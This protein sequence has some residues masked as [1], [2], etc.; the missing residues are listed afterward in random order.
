M[1]RDQL[2][3]LLEDIIVYRSGSCQETALSASPS[4][5]HSD[6]CSVDYKAVQQVSVQLPLFNLGAIKLPDLLVE[7]DFK[8]V[9]LAG[10]DALFLARFKAA[11]NRQVEWFK[12]PR[13]GK[14]SP[15]QLLLQ[16]LRTANV[17]R[18]LVGPGFVPKI[19]HSKAA[20]QGGGGRKIGRKVCMV[21]NL[22][23]LQLHA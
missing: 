1:N 9:H 14:P 10:L 7:Q 13:P 4:E 5:P 12:E 23:V 16:V 22:M 6:V 11:G 21:P 19:D 18:Q 8:E 3:N 2:V 15:V 20:G 17:V